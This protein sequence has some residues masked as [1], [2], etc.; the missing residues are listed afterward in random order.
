MIDYAALYQAMP[1]T[2]L[3]SW[4]ETLPEQINSSLNNSAHGDLEKWLAILA[5]LPHAEPGNIDLCSDSVRVGT[6]KDMPEP[7]RH[8]LEQLLQQLHP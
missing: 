3:A 4:L 7:A 1:N 6:D 8:Q 2:G 5:A